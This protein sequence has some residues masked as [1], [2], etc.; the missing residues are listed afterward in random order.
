MDLSFVFR[1]QGSDNSILYGCCVLVEELVQKPTGL[2]SLISDKQPSYTSLR[3]YVLTTQRSYCILSRLPFFK[4]HFGVL[5][6]VFTQERLE[7]L[8]KSVED[9]NSEF[10]EGNYDEENSGKFRKCVGER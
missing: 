10:V 1:L 2:L 4:L 5:N 9:S 6:S 8:T 3:R 7:K